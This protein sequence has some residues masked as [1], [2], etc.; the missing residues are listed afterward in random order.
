MS[1]TIDPVGSS[2][3]VYRPG[4]NLKKLIENSM[5]PIQVNESPIEG[6]SANLGKIELTFSASVTLHPSE[7]LPALNADLF[8]IR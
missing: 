8:Q 7:V 3:T 1:D 5:Q 4:P 6:T 2:F